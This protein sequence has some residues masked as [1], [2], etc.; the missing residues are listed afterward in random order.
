[1]A[2]P[3]AATAAEVVA[4]C[5]GR[6][7]PFFAYS[8]LAGSAQADLPALDALA[9]AR[10]RSRQRLLLR[11]L[12][13]SSSAV[14]VITGATRDASI[15]DSLAAEHDEWDDELEAAYRADTA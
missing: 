11:A 12:L 2:T 1:M 15:R 3:D 5:E 8:P 7:I 14:S 13:A 9:V 4:W 10:G 6:G